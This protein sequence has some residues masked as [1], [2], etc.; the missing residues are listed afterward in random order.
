MSD[1]TAGNDLALTP[2]PTLWTTAS[3]ELSGQAAD[4]TLTVMSRPV[5]ELRVVGHQRVQPPGAGQ[6]QRCGE[7]DGS[8]RADAGSRQRL[9]N[10]EQAPVNGQK[11]NPGQERR[12]ATRCSKRPMM[13]TRARSGAFCSASPT[14]PRFC[15]TR[16]LP[17]P[18][19]AWPGPSPVEP[20]AQLRP[21]LGPLGPGRLV[22]VAALPFHSVREAL[23]RPGP[24]SYAAPAGPVPEPPRCPCSTHALPGS[25]RRAARLRCSSEALVIPRAVGAAA[26]PATRHLV[27]SARSFAA[28]P[29]PLRS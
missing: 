17:L 26:S 11:G 22:T 14:H 9:G 19:P 4:R 24:S 6:P 27:G 2:C 7:M 1:G 23:A 21:P 25:C 8:E 5:G 16:V 12:L 18:P 29:G 15:A 13:S 20:S 3:S 10:G 28:P